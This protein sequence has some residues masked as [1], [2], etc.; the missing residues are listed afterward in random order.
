MMLP[1]DKP[2]LPR[3][4][5]VP[6]PSIRKII[7]NREDRRAR[8]RWDGFSDPSRQAA[9]VAHNAAIATEHER[10]EKRNALARARRAAKREAA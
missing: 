4:T 10:R 7:H 1:D 6:T 8:A 5:Y 3:G 9:A 2:Q